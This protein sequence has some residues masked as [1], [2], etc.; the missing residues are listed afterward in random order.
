MHQYTRIEGG[1]Y[2][3]ETPLA[4]CCHRESRAPEKW[5]DCS[6]LDRRSDSV[7][8]YTNALID[9]VCAGGDSGDNRGP[10]C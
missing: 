4:T 8:R 6:G 7:L 9:G 10:F 2:P 1:G 3:L 5:R